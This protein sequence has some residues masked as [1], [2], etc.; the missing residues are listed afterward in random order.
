MAEKV[1]KIEE[2]SE[3]EESGQKSMK[4]R[5][6]KMKKKTRPVQFNRPGPVQ[7]TGSVEPAT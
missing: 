2:M 6:R 5:A 4:N 7:Q 3:V 1:R